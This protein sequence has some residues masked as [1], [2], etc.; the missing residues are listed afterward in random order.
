[1]IL[2]VGAN[3]NMGRR[4]RAI[5]NYLGVPWRGIDL[6]DSWPRDEAR[7]ITGVII[8]TPTVCH[9][10]DLMNAEHYECPVLCEKPIST[11]AQ[12]LSRI[13]ADIHNPI[14]MVMQYQ[15]TTRKL[16]VA[17][18]P[19]FYDYYNH[20]RDG[21]VWDCIQIIGLAKGDVNL[22]EESPVWDCSINGSQIDIREMDFAYVEMIKNW[23][24]IPGQDKNEILEIH[25]K[26]HELAL[27]G[28][29]G[30]SAQSKT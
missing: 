25:Q 4:Y 12:N 2:I 5:L 27:S 9:L 21:L 14:K 24:K 3:G 20:G 30:P 28:R 15:F 26:T 7:Q 29:F 16:A 13:L 11:N 17:N 23:L 18:S 1:M 6:K 19:S 22:A 8:A 10:T